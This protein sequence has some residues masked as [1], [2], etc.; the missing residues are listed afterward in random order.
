METKSYNQA[1]DL[2]AEQRH[3]VES[4][5]GHPLNGEGMVFLVVMRPGQEPTSQDKAHARARLEKVFEQVDR[6]GDEHNVSPEEADAAIE[7][8][9]RDVRRGPSDARR[10]SVFSQ[11]N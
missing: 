7:A 9:V 2:S 6:H 1:A 4:M 10:T 3:A 11:D 5:V 8:A